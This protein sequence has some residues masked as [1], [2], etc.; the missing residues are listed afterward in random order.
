MDY[1]MRKSGFKITTRTTLNFPVEN[2]F[3]SLTG[4]AGTIY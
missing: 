3:D 1:S 4:I 2:I